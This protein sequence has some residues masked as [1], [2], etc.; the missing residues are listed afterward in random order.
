[1]GDDDNDDDDDEGD[2]EDDDDYVGGRRTSRVQSGWAVSGYCALESATEVSVGE[3]SVCFGRVR[4]HKHTDAQ[5]H[6]RTHT[7]AFFFFGPSSRLLSRTRKLKRTRALKR[8]CSRR[9]AHSTVSALG[10]TAAAHCAP[11][12]QKCSL[13]HARVRRRALSACANARRNTIDDCF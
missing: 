6:A 4:A 12:A 3:K 5:T 9:R 11:L 8:P 7:A 13:A 1:M 10:S 2:D